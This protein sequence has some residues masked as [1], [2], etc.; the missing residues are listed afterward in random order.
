MPGFSIHKSAKY[1]EKS[2]MNWS[3]SLAVVKATTCI[4]SVVILSVC[5]TIVAPQI[6]SRSVLV[7]AS[8]ITPLSHTKSE[9]S[10]WR[11][12]FGVPQ[13]QGLERINHC[14]AANWFGFPCHGFKG[15]GHSMPI[16]SLL[17][18]SI[19]YSKNVWN[20]TTMIHYTL[21]RT[22]PCTA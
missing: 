9:I 5:L 3:Y 18:T 8:P 4:L 7:E 10:E 21:K 16:H 19:V 15:Q 12:E 1:G 14:R 20:K 6:K 17:S 2:E 13:H 22:L 11:V